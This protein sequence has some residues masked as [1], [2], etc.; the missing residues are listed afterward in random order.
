VD[1]DQIAIARANA[2]VVGESAPAALTCLHPLARVERR[3]P[4]AKRVDAGRVIR[5]MVR[6]E[7]AR[8]IAST[9]RRRDRVDVRCMADA[10]VDERRL[11]AVDQPR[12]VAGASHSAGIEGG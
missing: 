7:H 3:P 9:E 5:V 1:D 10:R 11:R 8:E 2:L 12:V 4:R 6:D